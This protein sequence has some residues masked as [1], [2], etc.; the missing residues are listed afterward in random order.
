MGCTP[1]PTGGIGWIHIPVCTPG[2]TL[3]RYCW[4][5][6]KSVLWREVPKQHLHH[7]TAP[8]VCVWGHGTPLTHCM[9][10][11]PLH[12]QLLLNRKSVR[13]AYVHVRMCVSVCVY[14]CVSV[15]LCVCVCM[16]VSVCLCVCAC[17]CVSAAQTSRLHCTGAAQVTR[18]IKL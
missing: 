5:V 9:N 12:P 16:C 10:K 3:L 1:V 15:C 18:C 11:V 7:L 14:V 13:Y 2:S 17:A 4:G 8:Q 6:L